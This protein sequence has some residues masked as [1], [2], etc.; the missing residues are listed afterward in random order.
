MKKVVFLAFVF[1]LFG[2]TSTNHLYSNYQLVEPKRKIVK[3]YKEFKPIEI[4]FTSVCTG[5]ML[6]YRNINDTIIQSFDFK[7]EKDSCLV[8][9]NYKSS[10][11]NHLIPL[12]NDTLFYVN[13]GLLYYPEQINYDYLFYRKNKSQIIYFQ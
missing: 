12:G 9:T 1:V 3:R 13:G 6:D 8:I 5:Y 2:C 11:D 7:I 10:S 4:I